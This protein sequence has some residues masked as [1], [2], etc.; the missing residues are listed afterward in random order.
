MPYPGQE[1]AEGLFGTTITREFVDWGTD[2]TQC[3]TK[4][5]LGACSNAIAGPILKNTAKVISQTGK[6]IGGCFSGKSS[7]CGQILTQGPTAI[8]GKLLGGFGH[9]LAG[10]SSIGGDYTA[11]LTAQLTFIGDVGDMM[12]DPLGTLMNPARSVGVI[13]RAPLAVLDGAA[14]AISHIPVIGGP[15]A[16]VITGV[17]GIVGDGIDQAL[18]MDNITAT[19]WCP[20][21][22]GVKLVYAGF[23]AIFGIKPKLTPQE[24]ANLWKEE[25]NRDLRD[26]SLKWGDREDS[27]GAAYCTAMQDTCKTITVD[28][29]ERVVW[30]KPSPEEDRPD[31][32]FDDQEESDRLG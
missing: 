27:V 30:G 3:A 23:K 31:Y 24:K 15:I 10:L 2:I 17:T 21:C 5:S 14:A 26:C 22:I 4:P 12:A 28:N 20:A 25:C 32:L 16:S 18:D 9:G 6:N 13:A 29:Y 19:W 11:A 8:P 1:F 7:D